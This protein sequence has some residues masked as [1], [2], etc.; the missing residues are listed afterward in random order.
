MQTPELRQG[1]TQKHARTSHESISKSANLIA[2]TTRPP[3]V[4]LSSRRCSMTAGDSAS[5]CTRTAKSNMCARCGLI[6]PA[7]VLCLLPFLTPPTPTLVKVAGCGKRFIDSS[8][9]K[10]HMLVHTGEK[11]FVCTYRVDDVS[12]SHRRSH[13]TSHTSANEG[14]GLDACT[15]P[16]AGPIMSNK[17]CAVVHVWAVIIW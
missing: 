5:T 16:L 12:E 1:A 14:S 10:R 17:V 4:T 11:P 3:S 15:S 9:L 8:K 6:P 2:I 7:L 13:S